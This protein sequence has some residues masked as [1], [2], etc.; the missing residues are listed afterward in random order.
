MAELQTEHSRNVSEALRQ[1]AEST[2]NYE[3]A[4]HDLNE[5]KFRVALARS[6]PDVKD[7]GRDEEM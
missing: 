6:A 5:K 2:P 4:G 3:I 7:G 1:T